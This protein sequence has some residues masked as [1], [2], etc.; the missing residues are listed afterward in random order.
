MT[1]LVLCLLSFPFHCAQDVAT[2]LY[3]KLADGF[4]S[5]LGSQD[6]AE[7]DEMTRYKKN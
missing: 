4:D 7:V 6:K 1:Q 5:L 2:G 3:G